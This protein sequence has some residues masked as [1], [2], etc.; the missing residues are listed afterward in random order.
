MYALPLSRSQLTVSSSTRLLIGTIQTIKLV[1][2]A[3]E[4][5]ERSSQLL[6]TCTF[7]ILVHVVVIF[8]S[9]MTRAL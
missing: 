8:V 2:R 4:W 3:L 7:I 6:S 5:Y 9:A 1:R